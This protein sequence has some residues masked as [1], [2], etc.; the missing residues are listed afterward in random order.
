MSWLKYIP[1]LHL[2]PNR[3]LPLPTRNGATKIKQ[4][5]DTN[6]EKTLS[7]IE[8]VDTLSKGAGP[9]TNIKIDCNSPIDLKSYDPYYF[10]TLDFLKRK[11]D[12]SKPR[13]K[14]RLIRKKRQ[15]LYPNLTARNVNAQI[16]FLRRDL[17]I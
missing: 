5:I 6:P 3:S 1:F 4:H 14:H 9:R 7:A 12:L 13:K 2:C 11:N 10:H 8:E 17:G 16:E 15:K